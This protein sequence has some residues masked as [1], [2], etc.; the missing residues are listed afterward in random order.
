L[1]SKFNIPAIRCSEYVHVV[2]SCI[3][4]N[5]VGEPKN[6]YPVLNWILFICQSMHFSFS[7]PWFLVK[8]FLRAAAYTFHF[9][10]VISMRAEAMHER[11][12]ALQVLVTLIILSNVQIVL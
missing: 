4:K 6:A 2:G 11:R 5:A 9:C 12:T 8:K 3:A 10:S 7:V 1:H